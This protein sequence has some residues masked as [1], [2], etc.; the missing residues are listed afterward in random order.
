MVVDSC[1]GTRD[2]GVAGSTRHFKQRVQEYDSIEEFAEIVGRLAFT[3]R[4]WARHGRI[5]AKKRATGREAFCSWVVSHDEL[6][7][8]QKEGLIPFE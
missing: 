2:A 5:H 1:S 4:E 7:R 8:Y 6:L 3:C